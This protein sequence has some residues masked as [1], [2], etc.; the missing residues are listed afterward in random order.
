MELGAIV[1]LSLFDFLIWGRNFVGWPIVSPKPILAVMH[2]H[3]HRMVIAC[4]RVLT[5]FAAALSQVLSLFTKVEEG[6]STFIF[7]Q[8]RVKRSCKAVW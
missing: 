6:N 2:I 5:S 4:K 3:T 8:I 1:G 7:F